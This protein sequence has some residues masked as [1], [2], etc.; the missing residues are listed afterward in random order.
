MREASTV[1]CQGNRAGLSAHGKDRIVGQMEP[2]PA[3]I[4][5]PFQRKYAHLAGLNDPLRP[6]KRPL[7]RLKRPNLLSDAPV[8]S[9]PATAWSN[10]AITKTF[11]VTA[12]RR[13]VT[14]ETFL[15]RALRDEDTALSREVTAAS[16]IATDSP[17]KATAILFQT[18]TSLHKATAK[19]LSATTS[20][21]EATAKTP[22]AT[23]PSREATT[24]LHM[25]TGPQDIRT[26]LAEQA[27]AF[28]SVAGARTYGATA[29]RRRVMA[30]RH[31]S[32]LS[33]PNG[34]G[35]LQPRVGESSSLPWEN[36]ASQN[37][38]SFSFNPEGIEAV[39]PGCNP[40]GVGDVFDTF[41]QGSRE[42]ATTLGCRL[43]TPL[44]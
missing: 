42:D 19:T 3:T 18:T 38:S 24:S 15:A 12:T 13:E 7:Q 29:S 4:R 30:G 28:W 27:D 2:C 35:S 8:S 17:R 9:F 16:F 5:N 31:H 10:E 32:M 43:A 23:V 41:S 14:A 44:G 6:V 21:H 22:A 11:L 37:L 39:S 36:V 1:P 20:L 33:N 25:T 40:V 26:T 34:V